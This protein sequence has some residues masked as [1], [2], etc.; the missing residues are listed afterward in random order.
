MGIKLIHITN[1]KCM[2]VCVISNQLTSSINSCFVVAAGLHH[3][4]YV[5]CKATVSFLH[6]LGTG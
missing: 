1:N 6:C 3:M 4:L 2:D 5:C